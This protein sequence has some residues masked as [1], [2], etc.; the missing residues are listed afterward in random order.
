[1]FCKYC[2]ASIESDALF[3]A[4]CGKRTAADAESNTEGIPNATEPLNAHSSSPQQESGQPDAG[5]EAKDG[6]GNTNLFSIL[7]C[8]IAGLS[9]FLDYFG[10]ASIAGLVV[11]IIGL[12]KAKKEGQGGAM[13]AIIGIV[14]SAISFVF[15]LIDLAL[16]SF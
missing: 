7:G 1:M 14:V 11:S 8:V 9:L 15:G 12:F 16:F 4:S 6:A 13:V 10:I 5:G 2:G 3:C